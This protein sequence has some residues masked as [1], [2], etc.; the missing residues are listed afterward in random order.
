M[1]NVSQDKQP[2]PHEKQI[3]EYEKVLEQLR[4]KEDHEGLLS[5]EE[6]VKLEEKLQKL[7]KKAFSSLTTWQRV[8]ISR[9]L[10][11]PKS[12]DYIEHLCDEFKPLYGDRYFGDDPSIIGGLARIGEQKFILIAQEK[13]KDTESRMYHNF[14]MPHPEGYRKALRLMMLAEKFNLPVLSLIDTPGAYPCLE[15]EQRGQAWAIAQNLKGM[16]RLKTAIIVVIIGE[17]CSGGALGIGVGDVIAML[18]H[19]YYSVITPEG[20]ASILWKDKSKCEQAAESLCLTSENLLEFE[21]IDKILPEP[22]GGAHHDPFA[23]YRVVKDFV[24]ASALS[25]MSLSKELLLERRYIK[26]RKMGRLEGLNHH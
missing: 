8:Q 9:H 26:F 25:Y 15:A 23:V 3:Y 11:R 19:S 7:K 13:G 20:C 21:V 18:E 24:L 12:S 6:I 16:A 2:L 17:G 14:G 10:Q 5:D 1:M 22:L 4:Q